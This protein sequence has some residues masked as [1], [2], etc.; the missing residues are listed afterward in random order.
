MRHNL[1]P[2]SS[3][4]TATTGNLNQSKIMRPFIT[5]ALAILCYVPGYIMVKDSDK[6]SFF[7]QLIGQ[8]LQMTG[9]FYL[10]FA[11]ADALA[12]AYCPRRIAQEGPEG[13]RQMDA[14]LVQR[15]T[16]NI[17]GLMIN[18]DNSV[19]LMGTVSMENPS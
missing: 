7:S 14:V 18:P 2:V 9:I 11:T 15:Q 13:A 10:I 19:H 17:A 16:F 12:G 5:L 8:L 6:D 3:R 4:L 1:R